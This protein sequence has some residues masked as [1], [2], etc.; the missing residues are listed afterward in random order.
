MNCRYCNGSCVKK[1]KRNG[2]QKLRC[3]ICGRYQQA[4]YVRR[5]FDSTK[6]LILEFLHSEGN[7]IST[8]SRFLKFSKTT[9]GN[10]ISYLGNEYEHEV[11]EEPKGEYQADELR[12]FVGIKRMKAGSCTRSTN[13]QKALFH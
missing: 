13:A 10:W 2:C 3:R 12:T 4:N 7:S 5:F 1:G 9:I 8:L 6:Q 11:K